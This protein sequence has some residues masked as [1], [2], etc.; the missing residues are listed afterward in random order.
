MGGQLEEG[1]FGV[2]QN[3]DDVDDE[4]E[5]EQGEGEGEGSAKEREIS[6]SFV[7]SG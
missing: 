5:V 7:D 1:E 3:I 2:E 6:D 4:I